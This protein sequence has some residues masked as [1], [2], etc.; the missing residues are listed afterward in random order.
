MK[1][2]VN[3]AQEGMRLD[4][5]LAEAAEISRS[6]AVRHIEEG[7]ALLNGAPADKKSRVSAGQTVE[8]SP[9]PPEPCKAEAEE[10]PLDVVYEDADLVIVNKP[11][12]MVVHP[13]AGNPDGTLVNALLAHCGESLSGI[14]GELRPGIV[15]RIDKETSGLIAVAKN[16]KAHLAL[17][18]QLKDK[19]MRRVYRAVAAGGFSAE[20]GR[21]DKPIGRSPKDRKKMAVVPADK[22]RAAATRYT[23]LERYPGWTLLRLDLETG[24]THQIRVH[25]SSAGHPLM[26]DRVYGGA[27]TRF[28]T[29]HRDLLPGQLLHAGELEL[30]HPATGETMRFTAPL[31][32]NFERILE[33]LRQLSN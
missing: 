13:A 8:F 27:P 18:A 2:T 22:G 25:L 10:I 5:Y 32:P 1:Y 20:S 6:L 3:E 24:R 26:G 9:L 11:A 7:R 23:V 29:Q 12:G 31:P 21:I 28:E 16:D 19:T 33:I 17:S 4:L 15:H 30:V 14:G